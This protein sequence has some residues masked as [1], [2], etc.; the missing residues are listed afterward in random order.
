M[1]G[2]RKSCKHAINNLKF[3]EKASVNIHLKYLVL[4]RKVA[5]VKLHGQ[6]KPVKLDFL[7][8]KTE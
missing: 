5:K 7:Y 6:W 2:V 4:G 3:L 8:A 1:C